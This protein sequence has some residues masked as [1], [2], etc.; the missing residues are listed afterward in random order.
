[1]AKKTLV[2]IISI[3][4][5]GLALYNSFYFKSL[6]EIKN[7]QQ[8]KIFSPQKYAV[9]FWRNLVT[10]NFN[11]AIEA[12]ELMSLLQNDMN[13]AL[14]YSSTLGVS[15]N[16]AYLIKGEGKISSITDEGFIL[17]IN[18]D[19]KIEIATDF[20]FGNAIRDASGQINVSDF[21]NTMEFNNISQKIND[22]AL[23]NTIEPFADNIV[24]NA[25]IN[26]VGA[27]EV[28]EENPEIDPLKII[29]IRLELIDN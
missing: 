23:K 2:T 9:E 24:I 27:A 8:K 18:D 14:K 29:P 5:I 19:K 26:F 13:E 3:C 7:E 12:S 15:S 1:M 20:I 28:N 17:K 16:H 6:S 25:I 11:E 4:C 22:L 21:P 10:S